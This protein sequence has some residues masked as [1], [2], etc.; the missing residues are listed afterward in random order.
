MEEEAGTRKELFDFEDPAGLFQQPADV[1]KLRPE[2]KKFLQALK[3]SEIRYRRLFETAQDG[4]LI[5]NAETGQIN[6]VNPHLI[7]MLHYSHEEFVGKK[8]WEV[9]PFK[10][11]ALNR[12]AFAEL[13][14]KGYI[15]YKD[16][17]LETKERKS[18]AVEFV[19][20]VYKANGNKVIQCNIRN[21]TERKE[22][23]RQLQE[24]V[25]FQQR[26][27]D[28][29]PVPFFYQ[30]SEGRYLG[31]NSSF[32]KLFGQKREQVTGKSVYELCPKARADIFHEKDLVLLQSPGI[33]TYE[34]IVNGIG[35]TVHN[36]IFHKA[37]YPNMDGSVGGLIGAIVDI[38]DRKR[39]EDELRE[40]EKKY[41]LHF[42]NVTDMI[43]SID[44]DLRLLSISPSV[45]MVL[46]YK[47]EEL[48]GKLLSELNIM[49]PSSLEKAASDMKRVLAGERIEATSYEYRTKYGKK[50]FGEVNVSPLFHDGKVVSAICVSRDFTERKQAEEALQQSEKDAKR[51][52]HE[53][54]LVAEL[55]RIISST[56]NIEEVYENFASKMGEAIPFD[57][58]TVSAVNLKDYTRTIR[59][60]KGDK[61]WGEGIGEV[62]S[63]AGTR[64]EQIVRTKS[65]LLINSKNKD[66][67]IKKFPGMSSRRYVAQ[68][69]IMIPLISTNEVFG[70]L[71]VQSAKID[72]YSENDLLFV[73]RVGAQI[74]GAIANAQLFL[75][76]KQTKEHLQHTLDSLRKAVNTTIH[77][78]VSAVE[79]RD[80]YTAGHQIRSA[81]LARAIATE[82]K[83]SPERVEG[84]RMAGS[85]H[86][87]GKISIP[88]EIL[89][90][91]TKLSDLEFSLIKEHA[92]KGFE[93]LKDVESPWPLAEIIYQHHERMDGSGYPRH[94]KGEDI[95]IEAR[96]L[97][98]ADVVEAM[99]SH[100][101]Y[102]PSLG[103]ETALNEIEKNRGVFYDN[104]VADACL[105]LFREKGFKLEQT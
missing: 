31:C 55:G 1:K 15:R 30:D 29:L 72:A 88:A 91:P 89:S 36:V 96:I 33:Q 19:S 18:I 90:K 99:A 98:V 60:I 69:T 77:V 85:I 21:I 73:E 34:T 45:E 64:T 74:A 76:S 14:D 51:L 92:R 11:T 13:Q 101:P 5:L 79:A 80:P 37:T 57:R 75:E 39:A 71:A 23:N 4:I 48:A 50:R 6:D 3:A 68:S 25:I 63:L 70:V 58:I 32:E 100:R 62:H 9:S 66:D 61:F 20:N 24:A 8:L 105:R 67:M 65:S 97:N 27:I 47:P 17:P 93:M 43:L 95:L 102:R 59:Y 40:S 7:D 26:L 22:I 52:S 83:F 41:R 94:L 81:N 82:M 2:A 53:N 38:T 87:I 104:A 103:I 54:E 42:D 78:L 44:P 16:L 84:I 35:G 49:E 56:P 10:D 12:E 86:D 28:A 46:G